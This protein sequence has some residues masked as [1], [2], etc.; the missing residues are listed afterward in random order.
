MALFLT[1][2]MRQEG[3][4]WAE[5][6]GEGLS[7]QKKIRPKT[8]ATFWTGGLHSNARGKLGGE[9]RKGIS[10]AM[11]GKESIWKK[12]TASGRQGYTNSNEHPP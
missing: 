3:K 9:K 10:S 8:V 1:I 2:D 11:E 5:K 7:G 12:L 4:V 6:G